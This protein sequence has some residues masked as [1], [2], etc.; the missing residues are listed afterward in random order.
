MVVSK[1][2]IATYVCLI[3][4]NFLESAPTFAGDE[5][6][7]IKV[8]VPEN[9]APPQIN[10]I[11]NHNI[12]HHN[13]HRKKL[14]NPASHLDT[15]PILENVILSEL[16]NP[17]SG[18]EDDDEE[19][20]N[21]NTYRVI[22]EKS[23]KSQGGRYSSRSHNSVGK[24]RIIPS[25][26][27]AHGVTVKVVG[28]SR[29][30]HRRHKTKKPKDGIIKVVHAD[31][32]NHQHYSAHEDYGN[33]PSGYLKHKP[34]DS[35]HHY[36]KYQ[37]KENTHDSESE[38]Y[39]DSDSD[40]EIN[41][42]HHHSGY[43]NSHG[44]YF[45]EKPK[46]HYDYSP[47]PQHKERLRIEPKG[48]P[49]YKPKYSDYSSTEPHHVGYRQSSTSYTDNVDWDNDLEYKRF[50]PEYSKYA[51][52]VTQENS[53]NSYA[54][55]PPDNR[56]NDFYQYNSQNTRSGYGGQAPS[57]YANA[58]SLQSPISSSNGPFFPPEDLY[59][60]NLPT[61]DHAP[62]FH[63]SPLSVHKNTL[64]DD[65]PPET[66]S[67]IN[68]KLKSNIDWPEGIGKAYT[69]ETYTGYD[70]YSADHVQGLN[71]GGYQYHSPYK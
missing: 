33:Q 34:H 70:S 57:L 25:H 2:I 16:D 12:H 69:T 27:Q 29:S 50:L 28:N 43:E 26:S 31:D 37:V 46:T 59:E 30:P 56:Y 1:I 41:R 13:N 64:F 61:T 19:D 22:E 17:E 21:T 71:S 54:S 4:I 3:S 39:N 42:D 52:Y 11:E 44:K 8:H 9:F 58:A 67:N 49:R 68:S 6:V 53:K 47:P 66:V 23:R 14:H 63:G 45:Y 62:E 35:R 20:E 18:Y 15:G 60:Q 65:L 36:H 40:S 5:F 32:D 48:Y 7:H 38:D 24:I 51:E 55:N 10:P